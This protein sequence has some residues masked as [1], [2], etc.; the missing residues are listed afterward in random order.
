MRV[1]NVQNFKKVGG[2]EAKGLKWKLESPFSS[3]SADIT[4]TGVVSS[5]SFLFIP[6]KN[7]TQKF[8]FKNTYFNVFLC[9][10][11]DLPYS[12]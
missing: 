7:I 8:N 1:T 5:L 2:V 4:H 12:F 6:I 3:D 11:V 10:Y 9:Q